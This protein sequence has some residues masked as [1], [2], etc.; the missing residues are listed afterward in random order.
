M[1]KILT[2]R[3]LNLLE[4]VLLRVK[5]VPR[6]KSIERLSLYLDE[7]GLR[8]QLPI[9]FTSRSCETA[10][11]MAEWSNASDLKSDELTGSVSSNL[12]L[13]FIKKEKKIVLHEIHSALFRFFYQKLLFFALKMDFVHKV[14]IMEVSTIVPFV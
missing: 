1:E 12:T 2:Q 5:F 4:L 3:L 11:E 14:S 7:Y 9:V 6:T 10:G 13:S 8:A